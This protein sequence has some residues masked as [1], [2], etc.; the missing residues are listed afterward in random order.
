MGFGLQYFATAADCC[1]GSDDLQQ[2]AEAGKRHSKCVDIYL[3]SIMKWDKWDKTI[4]Y[5]LRIMGNMG[6]CEKQASKQIQLT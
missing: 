3:Q 5:A 1:M 6:A 4:S 2:F